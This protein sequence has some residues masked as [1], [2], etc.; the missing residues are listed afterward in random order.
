MVRIENELSEVSRVAVRGCG[1][2][3]SAER[4]NRV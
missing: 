2:D 4:K 3:P 1:H